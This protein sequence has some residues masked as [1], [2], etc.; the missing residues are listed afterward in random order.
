M[1]QDSTSP[2]PHQPK[3]PKPSPLDKFPQAVRDAHAR[4]LATGDVNDLDAVVLAILRD[5][6]PAHARAATPSDLPDSARMMGDLGFDSLALAEIVFFIEDLYSVSITNGELA[7][8]TTVG[9]LR[10]FIRLKVA[11]AQ[12]ARPSSAN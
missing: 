8:V 7:N 4:F 10:G 3:P 2:V 1:A 5:H 9:E 11:A 6:Q 12:G